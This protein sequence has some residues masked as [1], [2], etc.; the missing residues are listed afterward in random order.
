LLFVSGPDKDM[1]WD[2]KAIIGSFRFLNKVAALTD[3]K[4]ESSKDAK[5]ESKMHKTIK[6]VIENIENFKFNIALVHLME[7]VNYLSSRSKL[8]KESLETVALLLNPFTPHLSEELWEKIGN[9]PFSS[10]QKWPKYDEKKIDKRLDAEDD[11]MHNTIS[12]ITAVMKLL[13]IEKPKKISLF[14]AEKWKYDFFEKLKK[15]IGKTRNVGE[16]IKAVMVK[17]HGKDISSLVPRLV[18]DTKKI[19]EVII[20]NEFDILNENKKII[21]K[22]FNCNVEVIKAEQSKEQ[23]EKQAMPG[24]VAILIE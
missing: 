15:E 13:R 22:G 18:K 8:T 20:E 3:K 21:E 24:K 4:V 6:L 1:E 12:D 17:E 2:D 7:F 10:L 16:I 19:P 9:K 14:T 23:K 5:L 11:L